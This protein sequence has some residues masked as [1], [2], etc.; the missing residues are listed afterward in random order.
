MPMYSYF[1]EDDATAF[2]ITSEEVEAC[3][4][5]PQ[6]VEWHDGLEEMSEDLRAQ[7]QAA[8]IF[9]RHDDSWVF[10]CTQKL[11]WTGRG[12]TRVRKRLRALG[13]EVNPQGKELQNLRTEHAQLKAESAVAVKFLRIAALQMVPAEYKAITQAALAEV[14]ADAKKAEDRKA[15]FEARKVA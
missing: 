10:R 6:L 14:E 4:D 7:L 3:S 5:I 1:D 13:Y 2:E 11:G 12:R 9:N 8:A 15:Y